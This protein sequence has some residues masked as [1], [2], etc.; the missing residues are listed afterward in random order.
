MGEEVARVIE[1]VCDELGI[2]VSQIGDVA[3]VV[4]P[5][6]AVSKAVWFGG[7]ALIALAIAIA[8]G[9]FMKRS[10]ASLR[11]EIDALDGDAGKQA[12]LMRE[13]LQEEGTSTRFVCCAVVLVSAAIAGV[14]AVVCVQWLVAPY[15][16][17]AQTVL[18]M[19]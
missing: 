13:G 18:D 2:A 3:S 19:L 11:R 8:V 15:G 14:C 17:V 7:S 5:S 12:M 10:L 6:F 16:M 9:V 4:V 1:T